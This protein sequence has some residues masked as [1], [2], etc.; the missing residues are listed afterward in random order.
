MR[1]P[2]CGSYR[3][4]VLATRHPDRWSGAMKVAKHLFNEDE[5]WLG[6]R[7]ECRRCKHRWDTIEA[8]AN[9]FV[10]AGDDND[11]E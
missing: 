2:S 7:R 10:E 6:R 3:T 11:K 5:P 8:P 9:N 1:C 4:R